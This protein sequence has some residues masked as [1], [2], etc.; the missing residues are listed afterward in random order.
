MFEPRTGIIQLRDMTFL[1]RHERTT[2]V[3]A[4]LRATPNPGIYLRC[5]LAAETP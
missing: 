1:D 5:K 4:V 2:D 3:E